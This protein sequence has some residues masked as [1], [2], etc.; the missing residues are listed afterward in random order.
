MV[1]EL[2]LTV[3]SLVN[4]IALLHIYMPVVMRGLTALTK[5]C[6]LTFSNSTHIF[7]EA[8]DDSNMPWS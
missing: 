1:Y 7:I 5:L 6:R 2:T 3:P 4:P 8:S